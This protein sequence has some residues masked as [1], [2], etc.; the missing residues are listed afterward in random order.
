MLYT[1]GSA[2]EP[3][4]AY[5]VRAHS[6]R[7]R[8]ASSAMKAAATGVWNIMRWTAVGLAQYGRTAVLD[9]VQA[10]RRR[11][12]TRELQALDDRLLKDIGI[13]RAQ[14][15]LAV[16]GRS[17]LWGMTTGSLPHCEVSAFPDRQTNVPSPDK[18][19]ERAA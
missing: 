5:I 2:P 17:A 1:Q 12:A 15:P 14:I 8:L 4:E 9:A 16:E 13:S 18:S 7:S 3:Y 19:V 11:I 6:E 10:R